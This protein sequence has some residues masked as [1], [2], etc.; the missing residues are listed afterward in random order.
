MNKP[1]LKMISMIS[2]L[3]LMLIAVPMQP[4]QAA[5]EPNAPS[6][7]VAQASLPGDLAISLTWTDNSTFETAW[8]VERCVGVGCTDFS[9]LATRDATIWGPWFNDIGLAEITT[10][11]YRVRAVNANGPSTY[12]NIASATT[13]YARPNGIMLILTGSFTN[14]AA[15][16]T[17]SE[18]STNETRFDIERYELGSGQLAFSVIASVPPDTTSYIDSTALRGT[19]YLYRISQWRFD[20]YG[21]ATD[22]V[23][24]DTGPG[25]ASPTGVKASSISSSSIRVT[26]KGK[27]AKGIQVVVQRENCDIFGCF[28][29]LNVGQ[30]EA[31]TGRF[32][33][34]GLSPATTYNYRIRAISVTSVSPFTSIVSATTKR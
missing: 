12:S 31:S 23:T 27:F 20:V 14:G 1:W 32:T 21:G 10:Y 18:T 25:I 5:G 7:L 11:S 8:E 15:D 24:V 3:V 2:I 28:G 9:L 4:A 19:S 13:S 30:V 33:N 34:T 26:W 17:W 22:T 16:I 6:D 29:W